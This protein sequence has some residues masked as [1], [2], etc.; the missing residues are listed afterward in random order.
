MD[1]RIKE[2]CKQ[3]GVTVT[4]LANRMNISKGTLS[5]AINGNPTIGTLQKIADALG[6]PVVSFFDSNRDVQDTQ[7]EKISLLE[8]VLQYA[9]QKK[10][11]GMSYCKYKALGNHLKSYGNDVLLHRVNKAYIDGFIE[12]LN[13][14]KCKSKYYI[15]DLITVLNTKNLIRPWKV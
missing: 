7:V 15:N 2:V 11:K 8:Y 6:V 10:Q 14:Q 3:K 9:E 5:L 4:E 12:Y 13:Q 1:L